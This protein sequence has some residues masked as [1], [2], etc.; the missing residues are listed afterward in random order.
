[1]GRFPPTARWATAVVVALSHVPLSHANWWYYYSY[2]EP[3]AASSSCADDA[4]FVDS[5]GFACSDHVDWDCENY[6]RDDATYTQ[7]DA[8]E[9]LEACPL[10]C[11]ACSA[12]CATRTALEA[13]TY[14]ELRA[15][16]AAET[17][18]DV[19]VT[20]NVTVRESGTMDYDE[21]GTATSDGG[22]AVRPGSDVVVRGATGFEVLS[23]NGTFRI[24]YVAGALTLRDLTLADGVA[25]EDAA[26]DSARGGAI[27]VEGGGSVAVW[28]CVVRDNAAV[29]ELV[30]DST[31]YYW[32]ERSYGRAAGLMSVGARVVVGS[33]TF[34]RN[35]AEEGGGAI[36]TYWGS[37]TLRPGNAF[38]DNRAQ[39]G[40]ALHLV[41]TVLEAGD[42]YDAARM[43]CDGCGAAAERSRYAT[44]ETTRFARNVA[45]TFRDNDQWYTG[46]GGAILSTG[47]VAVL[48]HFHASGDAA[49]VDGGFITWSPGFSCLSS[50]LYNRWWSAP[51]PRASFARRPAL[52]RAG[53]P[54]TSP[55]CGCRT[56]SSSPSRP[57]NSGASRARRPSSTRTWRRPSSRP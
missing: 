8:D 48:S 54:T 44:G 28:G 38:L 15:I 25:Y 42:G 29:M 47:C 56:A 53:T 31:V 9:I 16:L 22:L 36:E 5:R 1:M 26:Y 57:R 43:A 51:T 13:G 11:G 37:L 40:A 18:A 21:N 17:C 35:F 49:D 46:R 20:A 4:S 19:T 23:G 6:A 39:G 24:L 45:T 14:E 32:N 27:F 3:D 30:V 33:T 50:L 41:N 10:S 2:Q 12:A 34:A 55:G 52:A 7:G